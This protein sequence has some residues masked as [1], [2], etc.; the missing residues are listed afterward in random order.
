MAAASPSPEEAKSWA[1]G[2]A[3]AGESSEPATQQ[4]V[5][6]TPRV[7]PEGAAG[8]GTQQRRPVMGRPAHGRVGSMDLGFETKCV[9]CQNRVVDHRAALPPA[10]KGKH[11]PP[12]PPTQ[13]WGQ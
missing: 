12:S 3:Q 4:P 7:G 6:H 2:S 11:G 10:R 1:D 8:S 13:T 5:Q 9:S